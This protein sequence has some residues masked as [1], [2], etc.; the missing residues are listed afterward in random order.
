[1]ADVTAK[2]AEALREVMADAD[3]YE[4]RSGKKLVGDWPTKAREAL[5]LYDAAKAQPKQEAEPVAWEY[6]DEPC[7]DGTNWHPQFKV[8]HDERL[9]K[10][11]DKDA[12]PLFAT[13]VAQADPIPTQQA[14][15]AITEANSKKWHEEGLC[16]TA[17]ETFR[18]GEAAHGIK[19]NKHD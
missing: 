11:K 9:A 10:F 5:R 8:T 1:M 12:R 15:D 13:P 6:E 17:L 4:K 3:G 7:F 2:L 18:L 19:E 16:L 14:L